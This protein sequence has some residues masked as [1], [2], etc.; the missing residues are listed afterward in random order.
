[1][2]EQPESIQAELSNPNAIPLYTQSLSEM[3]PPKADDILQ[4]HPK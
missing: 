1:M 4:S 2:M 3:R